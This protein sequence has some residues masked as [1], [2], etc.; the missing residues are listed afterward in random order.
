M[1]W[2]DVAR[3]F[4]L[5]DEASKNIQGTFKRMAEEIV[6]LRSSQTDHY[7]KLE[8]ER[9]AVIVEEYGYVYNLNKN[10]PFAEEFNI[11]LKVQRK[12]LADKIRG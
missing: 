2:Y 8:R 12:Y 1:N 11:R 6:R 4:G 5:S 3:E 9:C 7:V 10:Q